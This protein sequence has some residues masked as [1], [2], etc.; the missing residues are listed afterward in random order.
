MEV[1]LTSQAGRGK[2]VDYAAG[3]IVRRDGWYITVA[4]LPAKKPWPE[5][6]AGAA[7]KRDCRA[8]PDRDERNRIAAAVEGV[9]DGADSSRDNPDQAAGEP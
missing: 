8:V 1:Q 5:Q 4:Q 6:R 7:A 2:P 9:R 3:I